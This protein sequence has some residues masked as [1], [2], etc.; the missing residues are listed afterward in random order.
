MKKLGVLIILLALIL[1]A[2]GSKDAPPADTE[3]NGITP[4]PLG[5]QKDGGQDTYGGG[6]D[7]QG[8]VDSTN[9]RVATQ[10]AGF[11]YDLQ[12][13]HGYYDDS[14]KAMAA[15]DAGRGGIA[16]NSGTER[17]SVS[18]RFTFNP[19]GN[20]SISTGSI[21]RLPSGDVFFNL[22]MQG[23]SRNIP[24][25][26]LDP[27]PSNGAI[28]APPGG[29]PAAAKP[30]VTFVTAGGQNVTP[31][32][33]N[34]KGIQSIPTDMVIMDQNRP[35]SLFQTINSLVPIRDQT[36]ATTQ[37]WNTLLWDE[38][39]DM[40][41]PAE[42]LMDYHMW[43]IGGDIEQQIVE[44]YQQQLKSTGVP[45]MVIDAFNQSDKTG[46]F[47]SVPPTGE[48]ALARMDIIAEMTGSVTG[49]VHEQ[50]D[51]SI[52]GTGNEPTFGVQTGDGTVTFNHPEVGDMSFEVDILLDQFD[53]EGRA[54]G[55]TVSS[56]DAENGFT[57]NIFFKPDGSKNGEVYKDGELV[58][59]LTMTTNAD[60]FEN[61][62]DVQTGESAP[63]SDI[64]R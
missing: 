19:L 34:E 29:C 63:M 56:V 31:A 40:R 53:E 7:T 9:M 3:D 26:Y 17:Y 61:Y 8:N 13:I 52:P 2:C 51:F 64:Y 18:L 49:T 37:G 50:R 43:N 1:T 28:S 62:I 44:S 55:G 57:V 11:F 35:G 47:S 5:G 15:V 25:E 33:L 23:G 16:W 60:K 6:A 36:L 10:I 38:L 12:Q 22:P 39:K 4:A 42:S 27:L 41:Q 59:Q 48:D 21:I 32:L 30:D 24:Q 20:P 54:I 45:Q 46:W 14:V 58:G